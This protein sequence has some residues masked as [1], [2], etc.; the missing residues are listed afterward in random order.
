MLMHRG[1]AK[2]CSAST[3]IKFRKIG[4][5]TALLHTR[6]VEAQ[7]AGCDLAHVLVSPNNLSSQRNIE[8]AGFKLA[9][10]KAVLV[11]SLATSSKNS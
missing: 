5:Q 6:L 1:V 3:R 9:Y 7:T 2:L 8:R 11:Q 4:V 10:T